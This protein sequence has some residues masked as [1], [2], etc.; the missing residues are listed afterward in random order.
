MS[1]SYV[2]RFAELGTRCFSVGGISIVIQDIKLDILIV[3]QVSE[4]GNGDVFV[5]LHPQ[6]ALNIDVEISKIGQVICKEICSPAQDDIFH[7]FEIH[8]Q[9][10]QTSQLYPVSFSA[11]LFRKVLGCQCRIRDDRDFTVERCVINIK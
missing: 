3:D 11:V 9:S 8:L 6:L 1:Q 7:Q 5:D 2:Q 4:N 10:N